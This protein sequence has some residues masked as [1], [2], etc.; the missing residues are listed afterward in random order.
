MSSSDQEDGKKCQ[1]TATGSENFLPSP[2]TG[3]DKVCMIASFHL[4][5]L[6]PK[7]GKFAG[8]HLWYLQKFSAGKTKNP[9]LMIFPCSCVMICLS[10]SNRWILQVVYFW[11]NS[12]FFYMSVWFI[13]QYDISRL[14]GTHK[15]GSCKHWNVLMLCQFIRKHTRSQNA[16]SREMESISKCLHNVLNT[17]LLCIRNACGIFH[18]HFLRILWM[19]WCLYTVITFWSS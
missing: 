10:F 12:S 15:F 1:A 2:C 11:R 3:V 5:S 4:T 17:G 13:T 8:R 18:K 16:V 7:M 9:P 19:W 14:Y 6:K